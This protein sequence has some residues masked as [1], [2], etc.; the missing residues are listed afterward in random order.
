MNGEL[1]ATVEGKHESVLIHANA[2][3]RMRAEFRECNR[4]GEQLERAAF[5]ILHPG[6]GGEREYGPFAV[7]IAGEFEVVQGDDS[8]RRVRLHRGIGCA[9]DDGNQRGEKQ[10]GSDSGFHV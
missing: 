6:G 8:R 4:A 1:T 3:L 10:S 5:A 9:S 2:P 7:E